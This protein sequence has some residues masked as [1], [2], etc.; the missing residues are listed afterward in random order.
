MERAIFRLLRLL[1]NIQHSNTSLPRWGNSY[2]VVL[3][4]TMTKQSSFAWRPHT[5]ATCTT[6]DT[7]SCIVCI[8][9]TRVCCVVI[10]RIPYKFILWV[11]LSCIQTNMNTCHRKPM[12]WY[13]RWYYPRNVAVDIWQIVHE[14]W[15]YLASLN[16]VWSF[17]THMQSNLCIDLYMSLRACIKLFHVWLME[18][19]I[20]N[21]CITYAW[22]TWSITK[23]VEESHIPFFSS[24]ILSLWPYKD[25]VMITITHACE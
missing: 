20:Y 5:A 25:S 14:G 6:T 4:T 15:N 11:M 9:T 24:C 2:S 18:V 8:G 13:G 7:V 17:S 1:W 19:L 16:S 23:I 3:A 12:Y 21:M 22:V 10:L